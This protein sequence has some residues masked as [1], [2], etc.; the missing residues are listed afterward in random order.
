VALFA[1]TVDFDNPSDIEWIKQIIVSRPG[2]N[3]TDSETD[4]EDNNQVDDAVPDKSQVQTQ[5]S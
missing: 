4:P 5:K 3:S 1:N 2:L